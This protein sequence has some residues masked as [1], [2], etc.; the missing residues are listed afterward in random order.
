MVHAANFRKNFIM[1]GETV[2]I[3]LPTSSGPGDFT[4]QSSI[5]N[6]WWCNGI[7]LRHTYTHQKMPSKW[8]L[9]LQF[10]NSSF[11]RIGLVYMYMC[12]EFWKT[13]P[14][15]FFRNYCDIT[16]VSSQSH[17]HK[18]PSFRLRRSTISS[19]TIPQVGYLRSELQHHNPHLFTGY[20]R[21]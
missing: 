13:M 10:T 8:Y 16:L 3:C 18:L 12:L 2:Y 5:P 1:L 21:D 6:W 11:C 15:S 9:D 19:L 4:K 20:I 17:D 14:G 7:P